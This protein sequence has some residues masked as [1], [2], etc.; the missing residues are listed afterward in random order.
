[1]DEMDRQTPYSFSRVLSLPYEEAITKVKNAL[2]SEGFGVLT[3]IDVKQTLKEKLNKDFR[4]YIILGACN[5][6]LAHRVLEAEPEVGVFLPCNVLV[7]EEGSKT[8]VSAMDPEAAMILVRNEKVSEVA[9][10]VRRKMEKVL[11]IL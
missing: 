8:V 7:Y 6:P 11:N 2:K 3:E 1:V 9:K 5:P 10:Q 4:K